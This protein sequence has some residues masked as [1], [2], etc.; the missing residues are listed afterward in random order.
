MDCDF[1]P[2]SPHLLP[3]GL[4][5][6]QNRISFELLALSGLSGFSTFK[7]GK[8]LI[9]QGFANS[10]IVR[11]FPPF[12]FKVRIATLTR[13][14]VSR[15]ASRVRIPNSPPKSPV[16]KRFSGLFF[17]VRFCKIASKPPQ[18][19]PDFRKEL[20]T[21]CVFL[22]YSN[23]QALF[24]P[25]SYEF[26]LHLLPKLTVSGNTIPFTIALAEDSFDE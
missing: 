13:N 4:F 24:F 18:E 14:A 22:A 9:F 15:K 7:G 16:N 1:S 8:M 10:R 11:E 26:S 25:F 6:P 17:F 20:R 23:R 19:Q 21:F 12:S 2:S 5:S 3:N